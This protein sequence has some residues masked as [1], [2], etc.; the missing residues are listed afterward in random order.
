MRRGVLILTFGFILSCGTSEL[1]RE[2]I[3]ATKEYN[4]EP[5][6][7]LECYT[8]TGITTSGIAVANPCYVC[9]TKANT[10]YAN[11]V[12]DFDLTLSYSFPKRIKAM[13]NP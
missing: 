9:H 2:N 1:S 6:I 12:E 13:G 10:P 8:D 7:P 5:N 3:L 11:E 4:P